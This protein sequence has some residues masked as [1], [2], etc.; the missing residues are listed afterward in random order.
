MPK[1]SSFA[2]GVGAS[3][4]SA[5][6]YVS[7]TEYAM[8]IV[9]PSS[10]S[11]FTNDLPKKRPWTPVTYVNNTRPHGGG[12]GEPQ[13]CLDEVGYV[14]MRGLIGNCPPTGIICTVPTW[15]TP[16]YVGSPTVGV[17]F[18]TYGGD[19]PAQVRVLF[20]GNVILQTSNF[21]IASNNWVSFDNIAF[22]PGAV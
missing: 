5:S 6:A 3:E 4:G 10:L 7:M 2:T 17:I 16:A 11:Q 8:S 20:N 13:V 21:S 14:R 22:W 15:A 1:A 9:A 12:W 19:N 18:A